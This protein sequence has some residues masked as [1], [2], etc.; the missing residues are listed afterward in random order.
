MPWIK[1]FSLDEAQGALRSRYDEALRRA[2]RIWKIVSIMSQNPRV[3]G[4]SMDLYISVMHGR[5]KLSRG[6]REMLGVVVSARNHC[7]Y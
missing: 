5:S 1:E 6:Q 2:G 7:V 3:L 4:A